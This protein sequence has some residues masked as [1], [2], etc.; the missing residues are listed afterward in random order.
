MQLLVVQIF[1]WCRLKPHG[2]VQPWALLLRQTHHSSK[3]R[4]RILHTSACSV[5]ARHPLNDERS[6]P[7]LH[8]GV[9]LTL[10]RTLI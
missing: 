4:N 6:T 3:L 9:P 2:G 5:I 8:V 7:C 1:I 10:H